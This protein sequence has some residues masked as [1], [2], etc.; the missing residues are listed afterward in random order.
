MMLSSIKGPGKA[1]SPA[2]GETRADRWRPASRQHRC[3]QA[4]NGG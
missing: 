3:Q 1:E 2:A 4:L